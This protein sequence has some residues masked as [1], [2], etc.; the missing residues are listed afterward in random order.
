M[1]V[2]SRGSKAVEALTSQC[3]EHTIASTAEYCCQFTNVEWRLLFITNVALEA[4]TPGR[5]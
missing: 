2:E 3:V 1:T 5:F 4:D